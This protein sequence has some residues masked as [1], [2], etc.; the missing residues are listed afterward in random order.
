MLKKMSV[1]TSHFQQ[2]RNQCSKTGEK[3]TH[4]RFWCE[5]KLLSWQVLSLSFRWV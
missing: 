1:N 5:F 4:C 2:K 3:R